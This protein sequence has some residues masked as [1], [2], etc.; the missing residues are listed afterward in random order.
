MLELRV[1]SGFEFLVCWV[2]RVGIRGGNERPLR[3]IGAVGGLV[4]G[5]KGTDF[6]RE[7]CG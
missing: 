5:T 4:R 3:G 7:T 2:R 1:K 6:S